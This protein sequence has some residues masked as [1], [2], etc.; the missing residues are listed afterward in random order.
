VLEPLVAK[1]QGR[2]FKVTGDGVLVEFASAV[3]AVQ[4]AVALQQGMAAA[5]D[6]AANDRP[7][8]LRVGVNLGDVMVEGSDLYGDG[9]N[10]AARLETI[11]EPGGIVVSEDAH[12]QVRNKLEIG[13]DDLGERSLKNIRAPIRVYRVIAKQEQAPISTGLPLPGKPSIAVLPFTNMSVD[14]EQEFFADG[15]TEDLITELSKAPGLFVIARHS[16]FAFKNKSVDLRRVAQELGVRYILEGSARRAAGRIRI[17][18]QL[19]DAREGGAHLWADRFDRDLADVFAVQDEVVARIAEAL[20]GKLA[21]SKLPER[22]PPKSVEA[23]DLCVQGRFLFQ[24]SM[25]EEGKEARQLFERAIA[26]DPDYAE[27]HVGLA[28]THWMGWVN[29]FEPVDPHRRLAVEYARRAVAL[30]PNDPFAHMILGFVLAYEHVNEESAAEMETALRLDPNHADTYAT[31]ADLLVME[32][33]PLDAIEDVKRA[34][35]LNPHPPAW[36]YWD[37]GEAEYAAR[38]Y[39]RAIVTLRQDVTYGTPSRSILAAALAQLGRIEEARVEA[40]L[41]MADYPTFRIESF[42]DTQPFRNKADREH[43]GQGYRKAG[44]PE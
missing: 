25:A 21:A 13:F 11:A 33:R 10:I 14:A 39:E 1:H 28:W 37:Q 44:L 32:G 31:R 19:I 40:R 20:V 35:R 15:L 43:F 8:V 22:K 7:I 41:F 36:Y 16:S 5:N 34:M 27:A 12:R 3:N 2:V 24:R 38:Q 9:V 18:A 17:N 42:L 23:Y 4:C 26:L 6:G 30:D 29:W